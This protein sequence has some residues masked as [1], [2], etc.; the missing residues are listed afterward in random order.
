MVECL[1]GLTGGGES[2]RKA[3]SMPVKVR[4]TGCEKVL[5]V[6][7]T[8]RGKA[9][10]CPACETRIAVP[11][12]DSSSGSMKV[13]AKAAADK[14]KKK[15]AAKPTKP[16]DSEDALAS[17]DLRK[18]EDTNA[19]ICFKCGF[20]MQYEDEEIT[21]C[22]KCGYDSETGGLGKKAQ[23][24]Q[25]KGPDPADFYPDLFKSSWK[26]V[27][28]N[29][30]LAWR[31]DAYI[32]VC[33][34]ISLFCAF[35]YLWISPWPPRVFFGLCFTV[36]FM[37]IPGWLWLLDIE[38]IK[39]TLERKDKFKKLNFDFFLASAMGL[40]FVAWCV[41]IAVPLM[42]VPMGIA[43]YL[44]NYSGSPPWMYGVFAGIGAIPVLWMLPISMS[45]M[46]MPISLPGWMI[47]KV[48]PSWTKTIKA[49]S[50]WLLWLIVTSLPIIGGAAAIGA[51]WGNSINNI[52][53]T[54][55]SNASVARAK[56]AA[57]NAPKGKNAAPAPDPATLGQEQPVDFKPLIGPLIILFV[58]CLPAGF[59]AMFNMR[60]N[61]Q[62]TYYHK[63]RL[64]LIDKAKEYKY[65]AKEKRDE[66]EDE[67]PRTMQQDLTDAV[68]VTLVFL[69]LGG[70]GGMVYGSLNT[71]AGV[72]LGI[73]MGVFWGS[74][75]ASGAGKVAMSNAAWDTSTGWGL[76][77]RFVPFAEFAFL[78]NYWERARRGFFI[79]M[80]SGPVFIIMLILAVI[81]TINLGFLG[82]SGATQDNQQQVAPPAG[83]MPGMPDAHGNAAPAGAPQGEPAAAPATTTPPAALRPP[84]RTSIRLA[85][86]CRQQNH[87]A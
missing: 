81:G 48:V 25:M 57:E 11:D 68:V 6:P 46:A 35:M 67:K 34:L 51:V 22:P 84:S 38:V 54:M 44:V 76:A 19:R 36:A 82:G 75:F 20:D 17:F 39:L 87:A 50:V 23:K 80:I 30:M 61:G 86:V 32:A 4:C 77:V 40:M 58:M 16:V 83:A 10:K 66:D 78:I 79:Q 55:E 29:Q 69:L 37:V 41:A 65:V 8:A 53:V 47:W 5:T 3:I 85:A 73:I 28:K 33:L 49:L 27:G 21:E 2:Q 1:L 31:T 64:E 14:A 12:E 43:Y 72:T 13:P 63:N 9:V 70:I 42:I 15:P 45:H 24:K 71:D 26:F 7:D 56:A 74:A 18:A 59:L 60:V 62:Y 52:V